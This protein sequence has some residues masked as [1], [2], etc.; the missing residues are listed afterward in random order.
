MLKLAY[1]S[2]IKV[3]RKLKMCFRGL[4]GCEKSRWNQEEDRKPPIVFL[5]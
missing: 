3:G 5:E 2:H 1:D 4:L